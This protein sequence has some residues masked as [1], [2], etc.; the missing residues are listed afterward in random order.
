[1]AQDAERSRVGICPPPA[2]G[3]A[4]GSPHCLHNN[5]RFRGKPSPLQQCTCP[6]CNPP[7]KGARGA[8]GSQQYPGAQRIYCPCRTHCSRAQ[9]GTTFAYTLPHSNHDLYLLTLICITRSLHF[10]EFAKYQH[11]PGERQCKDSAHCCC[12]GSESLCSHHQHL[13]PSL[14]AT[15]FRSRQELSCPRRTENPCFLQVGRGRHCSNEVPGPEAFLPW[16]AWLRLVHV[17]VLR[18]TQDVGMGCCCHAKENRGQRRIEK[19]VWLKQHA[20]VP[21]GSPCRQPRR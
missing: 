1:M 11:L 20:V 5:D 4:K 17:A 8:P 15:H 13:H 10:S 7:K 9:R 21:C 16:P 14:R 2:C 3:A 6:G 19:P 18:D 12:V